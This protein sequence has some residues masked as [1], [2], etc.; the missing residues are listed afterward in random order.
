[1]LAGG[2]ALL[3]AGLLLDGSV[4]A[5]GRAGSTVQ[6]QTPNAAGLT[7]D[8]QGRSGEGDGMFRFG[9]TP[10]GVLSDGGS[11]LFAR[12]FGEADLRLEGTSWLRLRQA[13]GYGTIDLSPVGPSAT[14]TRGPIVVQPPPAT[15]FVEIE[16]STSSLE[17]DIASSRRVRWNAYGAWVVA[18]GVDS[19]AQQALPLGRGPQAHASL[20]YALSPLDSLRFD[21][22]GRDTRYSNGLRATVAGFTAGWSTRADR[23]WDLAFSA[24]PG[25]GRSKSGDQPASTQAYAVATADLTATP[26]RDLTATA[27]VSVEPLGDALSGDVVERSSLRASITLGRPGHV[28]LT[29][30]GLGALTLTSG[31]GGPTSPEAGDKFLQGEFGAVMPVNPDSNV[32]AGVRTAYFSRPL[33]GQPSQQ[34]AG[35]VTYLLRLSLLR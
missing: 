25:V 30:R 9:L 16:E 14:Q 20:Q 29:A 32:A 18:G 24:G 22:G 31:S 27:G 33:P 26:T 21:V 17:L 11:R 6:G 19:I 3:A 28:M 23:G 2:I 35:F 13:L 10:S 7:L 1:M 34:W 4:Q 15:R 12:G 8:V 5:E